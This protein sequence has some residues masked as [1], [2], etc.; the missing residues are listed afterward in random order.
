M[1]HFA[2]MISFCMTTAFMTACGDNSKMDTFVDSQTTNSNLESSDD[3]YT[4]SF[5]YGTQTLGEQNNSDEEDSVDLDLTEMSSVMVYS[6]VYD[7]VYT[8]DNYLGKRIKISGPFTY[9]YD[10]ETDQEYF[11]VLIADAMECCSQGMEF[12]LKDQYR[13]PDDY[14]ELGTE[15]TVTGTF[16]SYQEDEYTYCQLLDAILTVA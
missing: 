12:V 7:M 14:P 9:H 5:Q 11:A 2:I 13:Y 3:F 6:Q 1:K 8:S 15:I 10:D 16:H 4:D